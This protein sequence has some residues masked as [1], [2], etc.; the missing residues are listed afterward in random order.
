MGLSPASQSPHETVRGVQFAMLDGTVLVSI[1]VAYAAL[2]ALEWSPPG[3]G[4]YLTRF[5]KHRSA[6]ELI[7]SN[8]HGRGEM[9][10]NGSI[11]IRKGDR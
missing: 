4:D 10:E 11:L 1:L 6:L 3:S 5:Q 9:E 7:A 8:K 2:Q